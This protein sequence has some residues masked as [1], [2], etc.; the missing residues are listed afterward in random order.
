LSGL[1]EL[2]AIARVCFALNQLSE[3]ALYRSFSLYDVK[4]LQVS[5]IYTKIFVIYEGCEESKRL[6]AAK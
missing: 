5:R 2:S 3:A 4:T 1:K 6:I